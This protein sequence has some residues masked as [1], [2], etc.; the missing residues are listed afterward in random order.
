MQ[1]RWVRS[2]DGKLKIPHDS[3]ELSLSATPRE[4]HKTMKT[5]HSQKNLFKIKN[6]K[7]ESVAI[8]ALPYASLGALLDKPKWD[9]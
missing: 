5:Q 7:E 6:K 2:L 9:L 4:A 1:G 3:E 8:L